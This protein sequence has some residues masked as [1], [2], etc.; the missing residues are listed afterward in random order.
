VEHFGGEIV[1]VEID[2][3]LTI[4]LKIEIFTADHTGDDS[5]YEIDTCRPAFALNTP[6]VAKIFEGFELA[7]W[8]PDG[9]QARRLNQNR[10]PIQTLDG[11][12]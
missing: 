11:P 8:S 4:D 1:A 10:R 3:G 6:G 7:A 2:A 5:R 12:A 9:E